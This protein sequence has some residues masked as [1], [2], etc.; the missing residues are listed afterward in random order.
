MPVSKKFNK[1]DFDS[2]IADIQLFGNPSQ[3]ELA[4]KFCEEAAKGI[5]KR[6]KNFK[7]KYSK[8]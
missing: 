2:A 4:Y 6:S 1:G 3:I 5:K 8:N 7:Q